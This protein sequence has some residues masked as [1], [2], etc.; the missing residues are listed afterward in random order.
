[1]SELRLR[2]STQDEVVFSEVVAGNQYRLPERFDP[3]DVIIDLGAHI[4]CFAFAVYERGARRIWCVEPGQDN[5]SLLQENVN[6]NLKE[7]GAIH[8]LHGAAWGNDRD[9]E[10]LTFSGYSE[11]QNACGT[12]VPGMAQFTNQGN[13][14]VP[15]Y[16][17]D[18]IISQFP[19]VR[20]LKIDCEGAE[21]S[22]LYT[23]LYLNRVEEIAGEIHPLPGRKTGAFSWNV[24]DLVHFLRRDRGFHVTTS[25]CGLN[26]LFFATRRKTDAKEETR[27]VERQPETAAANS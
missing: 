5:F 19:K 16:F 21:F 9:I 14:Y 1:M 18:G 11:R 2:P 8:L 25:P 24:D 23:S 10:K 15:V 7:Q 3:E 4:G 17:A 12:V 6:R 13:P 27:E 22:I 20:L 26:T